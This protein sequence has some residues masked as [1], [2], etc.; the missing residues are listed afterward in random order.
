[1]ANW[2]E[3]IISGSDADLNKLTVA[4]SLTASGLIYPESDGS[5]Q[6]V[7][8]TDGAGNLSFVN[9]D[10][11]PQGATGAQGA[12]GTNGTNGA[13]GTQGIVGTQGIQ[14]VTGIQGTD[15]SKGA[16]GTQGTDGTQGTAGNFGGASFDYTFNSSTSV[17]FP[18]GGKVALNSGTQQSATTMSIS[19]EDDNSND[20][21]SIIDTVNASD[22]AVKG[23][24]RIQNKSNTSDYITFPIPGSI[25][26]N[27]TWRSIPLGTAVGDEGV[28]SND[29]D[30]IVSFV[31][32][33][34]KGQKGQKGEVGD[35]GTQGATGIQ[36]TD[37]TKG[38]KGEI[39]TQ[40][41]TGTQGAGGT[42]G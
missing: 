17:A 32:A 41:S 3:I 30:V 29:E 27:G 35:Q 24:V 25:A 9:K 7:L 19:E 14:G 38:Q 6:Q 37:G 36:G 4:S 1:M 23:F 8:Q 15:G 10:S 26:D 18:G 21:S 13:Q 20:I 11:G 12:S 40:G 28:F 39:G 16:T 34:D 22:S 5:N 2:R 31:V 33:G 42:Q